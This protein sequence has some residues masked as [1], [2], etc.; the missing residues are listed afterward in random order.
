MGTLTLLQLCNA[1]REELGWSRPDSYAASTDDDGLQTFR[2]ANRQ[3][4]DLA[5]QVHP[6]EELRTEGTITLVASTQA[7]ALPSDFRYIV[8]SSMWDVDAERIAVGPLTGFEWARAQ[9]NGTV[10]GLNWRWQIRGGNFVFDQAVTAAGAISYE[11]ISSYWAMAG[12]APKLRFTL[13]TD[14]Q[15]FDDDLFIE[16]IIWRLRKAKG[17]EW[18]SHA[19]L[20]LQQLNRIM[21]RDGGMRDVHFGDTADVLAVNVPDGNYG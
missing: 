7:Y 19:A 18:E 4:R 20:Y 1:A 13:D 5:D 14:T 6:W 9:N 16:G 10:G 15:R 3:G 2:L 8:P 21:A 12:S 11:Y 17:F